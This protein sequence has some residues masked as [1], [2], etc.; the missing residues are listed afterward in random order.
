MRE[1]RRSTPRGARRSL[2]RL[3]RGGLGLVAAMRGPDP[4]PDPCAGEDAGGVGPAPKGVLRYGLAHLRAPRHTSIALAV[5]GERLAALVGVL[6]LGVVADSCIVGDLG[7]YVDW[8]FGINGT[9]P[10]PSFAPVRSPP[11][12]G[13]RRHELI[14]VT[15]QVRWAASR[16]SGRA[17]WPGARNTKPNKYVPV[18]STTATAATNTGDENP[19]GSRS[20]CRCGGGPRA[21]SCASSHRQCPD[22]SRRQ[23]ARVGWPETGCC[24]RQSRSW[25]RPAVRVPSGGCALDPSPVARK[26]RNATGAV[27]VTTSQR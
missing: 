18:A 13:C 22:R 27:L 2:S 20:Q 19:H 6:S 10:R 17:Q 11:P 24:T 15:G 14:A 21:T 8:S 5:V 12:Q 16:L 9:Y 3:G 25:A 26:D 23:G 4:A 1:L 7:I